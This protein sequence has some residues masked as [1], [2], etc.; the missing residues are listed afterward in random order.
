M[1]TVSLVTGFPGFIGRRVV[2]H[3]LE[4]DPDARVVDPA[5]WPNA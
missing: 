1:A 2:G 5:F 3:L 4:L